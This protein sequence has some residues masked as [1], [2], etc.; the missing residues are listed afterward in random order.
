MSYQTTKEHEALR[1]QVRAFA[2][3]E[4][5]PIA[6]MNDQEAKFP[7]EQVKMMGELGFMGIPFPKE[8][9]G[10]GLD[11]I[12]YAIVVE[13]LGRVDGS[14]SVIC[15]AHTSLCAW[16]I[17]AY[18]T[19]E[20]KRKY[21][22]P[23]AS[24]QKIG[25]FGL[26]EQ[27]AGSDAGGTETTADPDG[28]Y[29]IL[30]GGKIFI[31]NAPAAEIYVVTAVT[32]PDL[33]MRGITAFIIEKDQEGFSFGDKYDKLGIRASTTC[34]LRFN[35]VRVHKDNML[36]Q[37]GEGFKIA[38]STLD[39]GRIG[40][41]AQALGLAQGAFEEALT[42]SK[43]RVQFN[44]PIAFNQ[45]ISFKLADMAT[46]LRTSRLLIYS[47]AALKDAKQPY[48]MEAAMAKQYASDRGLE[49]VNDALQIHGGSG[50][51]KGMLVERAYRDMKITTIYEG[52]NEILRV[53]IAGY[54]IG[55]PPKKETAAKKSTTPTGVTGVRKKVM[56]EGTAQERVDKLVAALKTDGYDFTIGLDT[57]T[58]VPEA[59]RVV[60]A[61]KGIGGKENL[62]LI[63]KLAYQAGAAIA[64]TRPVA[65]TLRYLPLN[66]YI[67]MSGQK[68]KNNLYIG[69]GVSGAGQHLKGIKTA[70]TIVAINSD[71]NALIFKNCDYGIVGDF[72]EIVPL[73][74]KAL[75]NGE[76]KRYVEQPKK[77]KRAVPKKLP[78]NYKIHVCNGCA[79]EYDQKLGDPESDT[80]EGTPF[81]MLP[82][83]W[84]CPE[85]GEEKSQFI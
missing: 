67:G 7:A 27:N 48:G 59:G 66:R 60:A 10:A 57:Q 4:I 80:M 26:T 70:S 44:T 76:A 14:A 68:F 18:G 19:E 77:I 33:G 81:E 2:E 53:V 43:D 28:D 50:Y 74:I 21:L 20:Q 37:L 24:G 29:Y 13:E 56:L 85:C 51:M 38:M 31:T 79:Y 84:V 15:S 47:A 55:R 69:V 58:P 40:I 54:V 62:G 30:N 36:G 78:P 72:A 8:Y 39:G 3:K 46:K 6:F 16:P 32:N 52:T 23:L 49:I 5:K 65:E 9:G 12:S 83:E 17:Y 61:G 71:A 42:Y 34:E 22:T 63:E 73:L 35:N 25:A 82:F 64:S 75:D 41:A 11:N 45:S 1:A